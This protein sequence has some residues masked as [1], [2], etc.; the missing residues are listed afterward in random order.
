MLFQWR[1]RLSFGA[2]AQVLGLTGL[3]LIAYGVRDG[4]DVREQVAR[5]PRAE[6]RVDS[7]DV[8]EMAD[9]G[10]RRDLY[11]PRLWVSYEWRGLPR[12]RAVTREV[13]SNDYVSAARAGRQAMAAG[14]VSL[15]INPA[16]ASDLNFDA[17]INATYFFGPL[18]LTG[19][20]LFFVAFGALFFAVGRSDERKAERRALGIP[21]T[22][23]A[24]APGWLAP[25]AIIALGGMFVTGGLLGVAV[26]YRERQWP[27]VMAR[28]D[29]TDIVWESSGGG[30]RRA[31]MY[32]ARI[33]VTYARNGATYHLPVIP[34]AWYSND[35]IAAR[36][37]KQELT[38]GVTPIAVDPADP[39]RA[40]PRQ[41]TVFGVYWVPALFVAIGAVTW[42]IPLLVVTISRRRRSRRR[43]GY[44]PRSRSA[45]AGPLHPEEA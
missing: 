43:A 27:V 16:D 2:V 8:V 21:E 15:L 44:A 28:V 23:A 20:G 4:L 39:E 31:I 41:T 9:R 34:G 24:S 17:G 40:T 26:V 19:L 45:H 13:Y 32:A 38:R 29:S 5:S 14:H 3:I 42:G 18:L 35:R 30:G 25:L 11:A 7:A 36:R 12:S 6:A 37:A 10:G 1:F 33:W 22:P